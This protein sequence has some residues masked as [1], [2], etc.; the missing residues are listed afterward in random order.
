M[1]AREAYVMGGKD[2][3]GN[4]STEEKEYVSDS[5]AP[6]SL[7]GTEEESPSK[8]KGKKVIRATWPR[9]AQRQQRSSI[10]KCQRL[11]LNPALSGSKSDKEADLLGTQCRLPDTSLLNL[12]IL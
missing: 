1:R 11:I 6:P 8:G 3:G 5:D 9:V 7:L 2:D 12:Y 10:L 4:T